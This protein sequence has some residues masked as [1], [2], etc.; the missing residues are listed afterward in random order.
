[1]E[2][3]SEETKKEIKESWERSQDSYDETNIEQKKE[4]AK[5]QIDKI[6]EKDNYLVLMCSLGEKSNEAEIW[7]TIKDIPSDKIESMLYSFS[8]SLKVI[9]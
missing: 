8:Q 4:D 5:N 2:D 7:S 1:M 9:N 3:F 6:M